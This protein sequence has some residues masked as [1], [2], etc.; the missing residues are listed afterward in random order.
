MRKY[1]NENVSKYS[2]YCLLAIIVFASCDKMD[3]QV[4]PLWE[5]PALQSTTRIYGDG[6]TYCS[7]TS[8]VKLGNVW[9]LAFREGESHLGDNAVIQLLRSEDGINWTMH[10]T[11]SAPNIDLRDP[12]LSIMPDGTMLMICGARMKTGDDEYSTKTY[13]SKFW[14]GQFKEVAPVNLPPSI[15]NDALSWLWRLTWNGDTGYG[16][17]YRNDGVANRLTLVKTKD[18]VNYEKISELEVGRIINETRIRFLEDQTMV[19]LMRSDQ[20]GF[21]GMSKPPYTNWEMKRLDIYLAGQ[22]FIFDQSRMICATRRMDSEGEKTVVYIGN[23]FGI[24]DDCIEL[25]SFGKGSD[26]SYPSILNERESYYVTYYSMH[27]TEKPCIYL[28]RISKGT[29]R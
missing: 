29:W 8:M 16:A 24:F 10:Q 22:D 19:A 11:I 14:E 28:S 5:K 18:G 9:F 1:S 6:S 3:E 15:D 27:E 17:V 23:Q 20:N 13:Y 12:N 4:E 26:T 2:I 25:P 21:M 7:F